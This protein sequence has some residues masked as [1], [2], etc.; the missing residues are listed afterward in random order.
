MD[1]ERASELVR[2]GVRT[3]K[4]PPNERRRNA[5]AQRVTA[6]RGSEQKEA[7]CENLRNVISVRER[8][9][10][11]GLA[12]G[13]GDLHNK[14]TPARSLARSPRARPTRDRRGT[15]DTHYR[16]SPNWSY[17]A[18]QRALIDS[19]R[20]QSP[21]PL[22]QLTLLVQCLSSTCSVLNS[23]T[24]MFAYLIK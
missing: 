18:V 19:R 5:W 8:E 22:L 6:T 4:R 9:A 2:R 15:D 11:T 3:R 17:T 13:R 7:A 14:S 21:L 23:L 20:E 16:K 12:A 1:E 10:A 24:M